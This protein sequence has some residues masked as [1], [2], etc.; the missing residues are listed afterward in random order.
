MEREE[1]LGMMVSR[2]RRIGDQQQRSG[3]VQHIRQSFTGIVAIERDVGTASLEDSQ[4]GNQEL[5][6]T[7]QHNGNEQIRSDA[8]LTES[9][10]QQVGT[11]VELGISEL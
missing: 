2:Q 10:G 6:A 11:A 3:I 4:D 5:L 8:R 7:W 9:R 1:R